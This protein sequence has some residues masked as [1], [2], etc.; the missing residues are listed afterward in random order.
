MGYLSL[1]FTVLV[2]GPFGFGH[3][4]IH[5]LNLLNRNQRLL[6]KSRKNKKKKEKNKKKVHKSVV[7]CSD[8][9]K[10]CV[11]VLYDAVA[12]FK[13]PQKNPLGI[14]MRKVSQKIQ[15]Y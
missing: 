8:E 15:K 9:S 4:L 14:P 12:N 13:H 5:F 3:T 7:T 1:D 10:T 6:Q 2:F 11:H